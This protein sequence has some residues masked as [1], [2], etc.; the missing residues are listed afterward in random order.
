MTDKIT[1][2]LVADATFKADNIDMALL[3][4]SSHFRGLV[5][6][7]PSPLSPILLGEIRVE[8]KGT[9]MT[10]G[11]PACIFCPRASGLPC[12]PHC[13]WKTGKK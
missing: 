9:C 10:P 2:H 12:P 8:P 7:L 1:F 5:Y 13:V 3:L 11:V 4:L 6:D